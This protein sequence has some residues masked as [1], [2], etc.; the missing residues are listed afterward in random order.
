M[1]TFGRVQLSDVEPLILPLR[2]DIRLVNFDRTREWMSLFARDRDTNRMTKT[3]CRDD[4]KTCVPHHAPDGAMNHE[5]VYGCVQFLFG[6]P[7]T[8][9]GDRS[10]R[11]LRTTFL[12]FPL[13]P[14]NAPAS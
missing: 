12:A 10:R 6:Q 13:A 7:E 11:I 3:L 2:A 8:A 1:A 5:R 14:P 9:S 4:G